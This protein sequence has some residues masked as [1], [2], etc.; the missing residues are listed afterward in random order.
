MADLVPLM[1]TAVERDIL[2]DV[3]LAVTRAK[4]GGSV[5]VKYVPGAGLAISGAGG[6]GARSGGGSSS[7]WLS[8]RRWD[9]RRIGFMWG[10][11]W[12]RMMRRR[13]RRR[14]R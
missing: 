11:R 12:C 2:R 9:R 13:T 1:V 3:L 8:L 7:R 4:G 6:A 10:A 5:T 14:G